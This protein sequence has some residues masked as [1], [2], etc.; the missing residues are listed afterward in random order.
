MRFE[1]HYNINKAQVLILLSFSN[2]QA[3]LDL[4]RPSHVIVRCETT[5]TLHPYLDLLPSSHCRSPAITNSRIRSPCDTPTDS[6]ND[7]VYEL[8]FANS[9]P[10][11]G[12]QCFY[13]EGHSDFTVWLACV[14]L[15]SCPG[16]YIFWYTVAVGFSLLCIY[17]MQTLP[18]LGYQHVLLT[19]ASTRWRMVESPLDIEVGCEYV[20]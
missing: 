12:F 1:T 5:V 19:I 3:I 20:K 18:T 8:P 10:E 15:E 13:V 17:D 4:P 14:D 2:R 9:T 6:C 11:R 16:V 7:F